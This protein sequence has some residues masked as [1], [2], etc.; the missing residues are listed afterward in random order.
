M[1][2]PLSKKIK[3]PLLTF[4]FIVAIGVIGGMLFKYH[5]FVFRYAAMRAQKEMPALEKY[6]VQIVK[7]FTFNEENA[8][9]EWEEKIFKGRVVY[10]IEKDKSGSYVHAKS[11]K[12]ASALYYKIKLDVKNSFP[13]V[14]WKWKVETFP[15]KG[16]PESLETTSEDDFAARVYV[17]FPAKF[18]TNSKVI[19]YVWTE[20][21]PAG[22]TGISP[23]SKN[24]RLFS[25]RSG[26]NKEGTWCL[27]ERDIVQD[28]IK[29]FGERPRRDVGAVA[30][31]T[32]ADTT[33]TSAESLYADITLGYKEGTR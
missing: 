11:D 3:N 20:T 25:L 10:V 33:K 12:T 23:Y 26:L 21:L 32:D 29:L 28:Y 5:I 30:F 7:W 31:M 4:V 19:E 8:L 16:S 6:R 14:K 17:I 24:I 22:T 18:I 9:K 27:E 13:V 15:V 2:S 1:R